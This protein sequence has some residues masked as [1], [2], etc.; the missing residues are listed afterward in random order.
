MLLSSSLSLSYWPFLATLI[1]L[2]TPFLFFFL[3]LLLELKKFQLMQ[4]LAERRPVGGLWTGQ[5]HS[6]TFL[7]MSTKLRHRPQ[8]EE[9]DAS[10]LKLGPGIQDKHFSL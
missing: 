9:E 7:F 8:T 5:R 3:P 2:F 1:L 4:A 6:L 10:A